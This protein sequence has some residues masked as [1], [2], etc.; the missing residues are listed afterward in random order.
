MTKMTRMR[1]FKM[2]RVMKRVLVVATLLLARTVKTLK[3]LRYLLFYHDSPSQVLADRSIGIY[4]TFG[5]GLLSLTVPLIVHAIYRYIAD[6]RN[7]T[8]VAL[9]HDLTILYLKVLSLSWQTFAGH[10]KCEDPTFCAAPLSKGVGN[11]L[12]SVDAVCV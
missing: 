3:K 4:L 2:M 10:F 1:R 6:Q 8:T 9:V 5:L 7:N 12:K 11:F